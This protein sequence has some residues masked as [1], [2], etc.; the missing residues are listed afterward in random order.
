MGSQFASLTGP[1][2]WNVYS[3]SITR[4]S[5]MQP[6]SRRGVQSSTSFF[7]AVNTTRLSSNKVH[8]RM[9]STLLVSAKCL[10]KRGW[11]ASVWS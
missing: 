2:A 6:G 11:K 7:E 8:W 9:T 4:G 5:R 10:N 1:E 3:K